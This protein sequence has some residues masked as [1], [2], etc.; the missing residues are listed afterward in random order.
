MILDTTTPLYFLFSLAC[1]HNSS[2]YFEC[3]RGIEIY[4]VEN[5]MLL[6]E[7]EELGTGK[8]NT[9]KIIKK[10]IDRTVK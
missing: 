5:W 3:Y 4:K 2:S 10:A 9:I 6:K 1:I 7:N 8:G